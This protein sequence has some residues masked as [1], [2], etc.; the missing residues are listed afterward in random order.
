GT[1]EWTDHARQARITKKQITWKIE[2]LEEVEHGG[3]RAY[4]VNGS[5]DDLPW[6]EPGREPGEYLWIVYQDR[7]FT[8]VLDGVLLGRFHDATD[9]LVDV[10]E[11]DEPV[12]QFPLHLDSC[13]QALKPG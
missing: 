1:V 6:Y 12:L 7:F 8:R 13:T 5:F 3:L 2:I 11:Q 4:L 10:I 9:P